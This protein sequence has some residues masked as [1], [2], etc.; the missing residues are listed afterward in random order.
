MG[1]VI[2]ET[3]KSNLSYY[4]LIALIVFGISF[5]VLRRFLTFKNDKEI[6]ELR[7]GFEKIR[8]NRDVVE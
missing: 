5:M 2:I 8:P 4:V 6:S 3:Q 7:K 1:F